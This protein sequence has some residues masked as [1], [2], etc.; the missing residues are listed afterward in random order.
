MKSHYGNV[1]LVK[2]L[3]FQECMTSI[4]GKVSYGTR[5]STQSLSKKGQPRELQVIYF[6]FMSPSGDWNFQ[7]LKLRKIPE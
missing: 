6:L 1:K 2:T 4:D 3:S 5:Y 7:I